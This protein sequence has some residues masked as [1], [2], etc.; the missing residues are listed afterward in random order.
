MAIVV[1]EAKPNGEELMITVK[2]DTADEQNSAEAKKVAYAALPKHGFAGA[3]IEHHD[4]IAKKNEKTE[5]MEFFRTFRCVR[6]L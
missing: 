3:G 1:H 6:P 4:R 2:A 5:K